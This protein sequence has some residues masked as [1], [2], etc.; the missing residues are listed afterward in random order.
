MNIHI[1][2]PFRRT[3]IEGIAA[4]MRRNP[5][6]LLLKI[7]SGLPYGMSTILPGAGIYQIL[8]TDYDNYAV[9]AKCT[10]FGF[11]HIGNSKYKK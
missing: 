5:G 3:L 1:F 6:Q 10:S 2:R 8:T 4:S 7:N 11:F 9:L